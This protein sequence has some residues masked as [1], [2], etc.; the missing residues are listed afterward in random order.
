[1]GPYGYH[2]IPGGKYIN[3]VTVQVE[4]LAHLNGIFIQIPQ[5]V[6]NFFE[7]WSS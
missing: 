2:Y 1:M 6:P 4:T 5:L 7:I 3:T